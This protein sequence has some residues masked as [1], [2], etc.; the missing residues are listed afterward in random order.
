MRH[1]YDAQVYFSWAPESSSKTVREYENKYNQISQILDAN[2]GI[3]DLVDGSLKKL[4]RPGKKGRRADYTSEILL[5]A[6]IVHQLESLP[7]RGTEILLS[8]S[9]FLQDFTF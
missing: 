6:M 3:L 8:H 2:P 7:L 9:V 5:R 1:K 4:C